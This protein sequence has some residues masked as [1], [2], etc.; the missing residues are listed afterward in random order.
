MNFLKRYLGEGFVEDIKKSEI[1]IV[2]NGDTHIVSP[3]ELYVSLQIV[4]RTIL[5]LLIQKLRPLNAGQ[6]TDIE[7]LNEKNN[8]KDIIHLD[9]ISHDLYSGHIISQGKIIA[10]FSYRSLAA[11]GLMI[12]STY[13]LYDHETNKQHELNPEVDYN[14]VQKMID[15]RVRL[16]SIIQDVVSQKM[17]EKDALDSLIRNKINEYLSSFKSMKN[18]LLSNEESED[19]EASELKEVT[20]LAEE[21]S[22]SEN[23]D[24]SEEGLDEEEIAL[25]KEDLEEIE[26]AEKK[27]KGKGKS[28]LKDFLTKKSE[29]QNSFKS[30]GASIDCPDCGSSLYKG[31]DKIN[32]CICY[33]QF[34]NEDIKI[35]KKSENYK[36]KFPK[37]FDVDNM[38]MLMDA[39]KKKNN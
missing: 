26:E 31:G 32:L 37:K 11:V 33:G 6:S 20:S 18:T 19:I 4:P 34:A 38:G 7:W 2:K 23:E 15:E 21:C 1:N 29:K 9:K 14:K 39:I 27:T 22:D 13:E 30:F 36:L 17:S 28:K 24:D 5:S 3:H 8:T 12:M 16:N 25:D 35:I 10:K